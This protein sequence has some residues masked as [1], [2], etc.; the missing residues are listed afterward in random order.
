[1][2]QGFLPKPA[3]YFT[4][5][6]LRR[7]RPLHLSPGEMT[8]WAQGLNLPRRG[9]RV[10]YAGIY[11]IMDHAEALLRMSARLPEGRFQL[12]SRLLILLQKFG[13]DQIAIK[14][15]QKTKPGK[16]F[17]NSLVSAVKVL[18]RLKVDIA[19][20]YEEEPWCGIELHTYGL[21]DEFSRHAEK[22]TQKFKELGVK[23]IIT[24]D[25]LSAVT[26]KNFYPEVVDSFDL[27]VKH[28]T[29]VVADKLKGMR[30]PLKITNTSIVFS[31]PCYLARY[32][33]VTEEPR[34]II[35]SIKGAR[36]KEAESN[37]LAT[38][39]DGGGGLEV[40]FPRLAIEMAKARAK[41]LVEAGA[42]KIVTSCPVCVMMLK[43]GLEQVDSHT[44]VIN[45]EDL[46]L[47][48]LGE[49]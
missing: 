48:A 20:L 13:L 37:K 9:E 29:T 25:I 34:K 1:V 39:C 27:E 16:E 41:E 7:G 30:Q 19:Y 10:F 31:D 44:E 8:A 38:K 28:F 33:G 21:L 18:S 6:T 4:N 26:F 22:V 36:L 43:L 15:G 23:E 46:L 32:M 2:E 49:T 24:P 35:Q 11:P 3:V 17:R 12:L 42:E 45:I 5:N 40:I 47:Q 14:L